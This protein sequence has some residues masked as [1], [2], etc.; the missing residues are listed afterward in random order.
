[1][2]AV[3]AKNDASRATNFSDK[4]HHRAHRPRLLAPSPTPALSLS[5]SLSLSPSLL[6]SSSSFL[7]FTERV[8]RACTLIYAYN[9]PTLWTVA[10]ELLDRRAFFFLLSLSLSLSL[11]LRLSSGPHFQ[12]GPVRALDGVRLLARSTYARVISRVTDLAR[13][14]SRRSLRVPWLFSRPFEISRS[15]IYSGFSGGGERGNAVI[16]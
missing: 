4:H 10:Q 15:S 11:S 8:L 7:S 6:L 13:F 3:R 9:V 2:R 5:L 14:F 16:S 1:M 12:R